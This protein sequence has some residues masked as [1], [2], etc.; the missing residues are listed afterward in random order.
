[1][2][3]GEKL[4]E[5]GTALAACLCR[6][7]RLKHQGIEEH[8]QDWTRSK[9]LCEEVVTLL[10]SLFPGGGE[11]YVVVGFLRWNISERVSSADSRGQPSLLKPNPP[12]P[13]SN[14]KQC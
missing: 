1:M 4:S 3:S 7:S 13:S 14:Q 9:M 11:T 10:R 2:R 8:M 6:V 12:F 5:P